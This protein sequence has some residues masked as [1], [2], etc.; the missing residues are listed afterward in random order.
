M[1]KGIKILSIFS[2]ATQ[3]FEEKTEKAPPANAW[4]DREAYWAD[5]RA[6]ISLKEKQRRLANGYYYRTDKRKMFDLIKY[7]EDAL[8]GMSADELESRRK[9]GVYGAEKPSGYLAPEPNYDLT[10]CPDNVIV[11][12]CRYEYD[13]RHGKGGRIKNKFCTTYRV[14][15]PEHKYP[16]LLF[17]A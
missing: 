14:I 15:Q 5:D 9:A 7:R 1:F 11:D 2:A 12:V 6:G 8:A 3:L 10:D 16:K 13:L 4:F 17:T